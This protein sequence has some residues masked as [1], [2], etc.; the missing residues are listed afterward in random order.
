MYHSY[1][2][3]CIY[4]CIHIIHIQPE[5][6]GGGVTRPLRMS[7]EALSKLAL[8]RAHKNLRWELYSNHICIYIYIYLY[9]FIRLYMYFKCTCI[10]IYL[11]KHI[12]VCISMNVYVHGGTCAFSMYVH[13]FWC[14]HIH[15][16]LHTQRQDRKDSRYKDIW[17]L[18]FL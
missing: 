6:G 12:Y 4:I 14:I 16:G 7:T 15:Y 9:E 17:T 2:Y 8:W 1:I 13:T 18:S 3:T 10:H 11:Y 5:E